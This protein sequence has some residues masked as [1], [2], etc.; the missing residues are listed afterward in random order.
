MYPPIFAASNSSATQSHAS[1]SRPLVGSPNRRDHP[2]N[3]PELRLELFERNRLAEQESLVGH[4]PIV[5]QEGQLR[6][7][8]HP[9][10]DHMQM[11]TVC[12]IDDGRASSASL[13]SISIP[14]TNS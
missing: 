1:P 4:A 13:P 11:K 12:Q 14:S 7:G 10:C 9:F 6:L 3:L 5:F 2:L 8:F